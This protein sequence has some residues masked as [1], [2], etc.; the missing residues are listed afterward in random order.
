MESAYFFPQFCNAVFSMRFS[1]SRAERRLSHV[2][3]FPDEIVA[4]VTRI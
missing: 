1:S 3:F 2:Y 4:I